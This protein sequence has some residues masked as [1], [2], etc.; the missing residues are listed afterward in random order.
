MTQYVAYYRV[1]TQKQGRSGLGLD[2]QQSAVRAFIKDSQL[3]AEF[4][5][6]ES[7]KNNQRPQLEAAKR[8]ARV[9]RSTLIVA[10]LDR[11]SRNAG[12]LWSLFDSKLDIECADMPGADRARI[13]I[14]AWFADWEREQI[15][16]RTKAALQ[17][18]KKRG[19]KLGGNK[20]NLAAAG[21]LGRQRSIV[22][23][24]ANAA[25]R[26]ADRLHYIDL[27]QQAG[28]TTLRAIAA[29]LNES[30]I[31]APASRYWHPTTVSR[32]LAQKSTG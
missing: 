19:R 26:N 22:V 9:T 25:E 3:I 1:S 24:K 23:R 5:E 11:L 16:T 4:T 14:L 13:G 20:G 32:V 2:A 15:S 17:E 10:K 30:G 7:G 31:E 27:A 12:F 21:I 28:H 18:A 8:H 29:Y 6:V